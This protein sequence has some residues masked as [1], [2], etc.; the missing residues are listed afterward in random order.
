MKAETDK[1]YEAV[2]KHHEKGIVNMAH[3]DDLNEAH[4]WL[5]ARWAEVPG[6]RP[7]LDCGAAIYDQHDNRKRVL[8]IGDAYLVKED[9]EKRG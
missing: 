9:G 3:F 2:L 4:G 1:R 5:R 8:T 6:E 7:E